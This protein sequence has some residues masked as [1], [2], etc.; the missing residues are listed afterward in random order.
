MKQQTDF[1]AYLEFKRFCEDCKEGTQPDIDASLMDECCK[2]C[3][4][5]KAIDALSYRIPKCIDI[6]ESQSEIIYFCPTCGA[7]VDKTK[8]IHKLTC[9]PKYC[10]YCGQR[11]EEERNHSYD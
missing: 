1:L 3:K 8:K 6:K 11:I 7:F 2:V 5:K 4:I 10:K 9:L